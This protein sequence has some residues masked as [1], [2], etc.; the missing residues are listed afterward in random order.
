M[1]DPTYPAGFPNPDTDL[2]IRTLAPVDR[3]E[4]A[5]GLARQQARFS[6][7][8]K[9]F[10]LGLTLLNA[11]QEA[12]ETW[13]AED[14]AMGTL[15]FDMPFVTTGG[16]VNVKVRFI[17]G[18]YETVYRNHLQ[19]RIRAQMEQFIV[20]DIDAPVVPLIPQWYQPRETLVANRD[21]VAPD[22][23]LRAFDCDPAAN[24]GEII[25]D[26]T[27]LGF[28]LEVGIKLG[29]LGKVI[30][31]NVPINSV[32]A[33][34]TLID[35]TLVKNTAK[36]L[37]CS[38]TDP[39]G[40]TITYSAGLVAPSHGVLTSINATT[41]AVLYTPTTGYTGPDNFTIKA[42]DGNGGIT[43][44]TVVVSVNPPA[45]TWQSVA[46]ELGAYGIYESS[47]ITTGTG[48]ITGW[49]DSS[50]NA[51]HL[52]DSLYATAKRAALTSGKCQCIRVGDRS[53]NGTHV[54]LSLSQCLVVAGITVDTKPST[55]NNGWLVMT[56]TAGTTAFV[57][58]TYINLAT[59][60][61]GNTQFSVAV[62]SSSSSSAQATP[63][64]TNTYKAVYDFGQRTAA[65]PTRN[66]VWMAQDG[67]VNYISSGTPVAVNCFAFGARADKANFTL[68][69][70]VTGFV[71][72]NNPS[73]FDDPVKAARLA[74]L[75]RLLKAAM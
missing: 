18:E 10:Q 54:G 63:L 19:W 8:Q 57:N 1:P 60:G 64:I 21:L 37:D 45:D 43:Y 71:V 27:G 59:D 41:G 65:T 69:C 14:L 48:G 52:N 56:Y 40:D 50:G 75:R 32:P 49:N 72:F 46:L 73:Q 68:D 34:K 29:S 58:A 11:Q 53:F 9:T 36:S 42:D 2:S 17:G 55:S 47:G 74:D 25:I 38:T 4:M 51:H 61:S 31:T 62:N 13:W 70:T 22:D 15:W 39:D 5:S 26:Q 35:S 7:A 30:I 28:D 44:V 23:N 12:F 33:P 67:F 24:A 20:Q 3:T 16:I 66:W 6:T